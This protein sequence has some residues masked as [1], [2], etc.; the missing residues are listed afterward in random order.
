MVDLD[1]GVDVKVRIDWKVGI[2]SKVGID[3]KVVLNPKVAVDC[4]L[5]QCADT[6]R[7]VSDQFPIL[8]GCALA[9]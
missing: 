3:L 1:V 8:F 7:N 6:S 2:D 4:V 5:R 9:R